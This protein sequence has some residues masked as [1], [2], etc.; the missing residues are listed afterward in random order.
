MAANNSISDADVSSPGDEPLGMDEQTEAD[1]QSEFTQRC[2]RV[3]RNLISDS[4][5]TFICAMV[6]GKEG[7][8]EIVED[9]CT[10]WLTNHWKSSCKELNLV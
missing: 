8:L 6:K 9:S 5:K 3:A 2:R 4:C 10:L 1:R 7:S